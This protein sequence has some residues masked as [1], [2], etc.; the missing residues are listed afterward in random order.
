MGVEIPAG[1]LDSSSI[2]FH[3]LWIRFRAHSRPSS[4][5]PRTNRCGP[6]SRPGARFLA[7][8]D[9]QAMRAR[10]SAWRQVPGR[11]GPTGDAGQE[12]GLAP[13]LFLYKLSRVKSFKSVKFHISPHRT[14]PQDYHP[15]YTSHT[16]HLFQNG[17]SL[18]VCACNHLRNSLQRD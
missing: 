3:L 12:V 9:Q 16:Y 4:W 8:S 14:T 2:N 6:G 18:D 11:L 5:P 13:S 7:A 15:K 17:L 10:K 1:Q